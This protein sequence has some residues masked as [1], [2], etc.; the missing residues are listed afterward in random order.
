MNPPFRVLV[1][2]DTRSFHTERYVQELRNQ[3]CRV[4]T[5][6]LEHGD[7]LHVHLRRTG[8][9]PQ[10]HYLCAAQQVRGLI[11]KFKPD[12]VNA[13]FATGYGWLAARSIGKQCPPIVLHLW[14]SDILQVPRKSILH[15]RKAALA[16]KRAGLVIA[17]SNYLIEE[18]MKIH[19]I[20]TAKVIYWGLERKY[21]ALSDTKRQ[22]GKPLRIIMPRHHE[23]I[24]NN[25]FALRALTPLLMSGAVTI[26]VPDWGSLA[27][28]FKEKSAEFSA[29]A[30]NFYRRLPRD[31]YIQL[32]SEHDVYLSTSL[33]DSSPAS[34]IEACGLGLV[35]ICADIPGVR[36]WMSGVNG[37]LVKGSDEE[38]LQQAVAEIARS[39][40]YC[41]TIRSE[42]HERVKREAIFE[43]AVAE[44]LGSMI[45]LVETRQ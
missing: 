22:F 26:T 40:N 17:D 43:N 8:L 34:L 38:A 31:Q 35:P 16:L 42:N 28:H 41:T 11:K 1:L 7:M 9:I 39:G 37:F 12:V 32:L 21:L 19:E 24:Y 27:S 33:S 36:E 5:A 2:A 20:A 29:Q 4:V 14:G 10:L 15:R 13:H 44:T 18:A 30:V 45:S 23:P 25:A 6:S 3:G